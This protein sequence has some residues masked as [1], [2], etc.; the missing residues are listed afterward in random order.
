MDSFYT[1]NSCLQVCFLSSL[2]GLRRRLL[3]HL[4]LLSASLLSF[5]LKWTKT[6]IAFALATLV[7]KFAFFRP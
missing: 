6:W 1:C 7:Y 4:N 2:S 3:L 5:V